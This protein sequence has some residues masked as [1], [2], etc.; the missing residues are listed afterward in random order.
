MERTL[1][2]GVAAFA[3]IFSSQALAQSVAVEINPAQQ[4]TIKDYIVQQK[5][6]SAPVKG[7]I[8]VGSTLPA[9]IELR[10]VPA[11]WGSTVSKYS[12]AYSDNRVYFVQPSTRKV[13]RILGR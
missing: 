11:G 12:Y 10:S 13:V 7:S 3:V 2:A 4:T 6:P 1:L 9:D 8:L 5:V